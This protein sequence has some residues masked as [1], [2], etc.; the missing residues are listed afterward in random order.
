MKIN[1]STGKLR[2]IERVRIEKKNLRDI[3]GFQKSKLMKL[4]L[5]VCNVLCRSICQVNEHTL[6]GKRFSFVNRD[7]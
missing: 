5:I 1:R 4:K 2:Y 6:S 3:R 7:I